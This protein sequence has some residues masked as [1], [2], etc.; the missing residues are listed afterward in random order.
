MSFDVY[1]QWFQ[2]GGPQGVPEDRVRSVFGDALKAQEAFGWRLFY[3]PGLESDV[4]VS[5][6]DGKVDGLTVNRPVEAPA[7]WQSLFDFLGIEN[8]VFYFPGSGLFIRSTAVAAHLP[9][10]MVE[11]LG[12]PQVVSSAAALRRTLDAA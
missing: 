8:A 7:L 3:G 1:V 10:E 11:A 2:D 4:F 12:P 9:P 5:G 6:R